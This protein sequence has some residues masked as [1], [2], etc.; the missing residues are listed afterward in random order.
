MSNIQQK[1]EEIKKGGA[2]KY[3]E[4]A[5]KNNKLF[6]RERIKL[7]LDPG[8]DFIE[9]GLFAN[10]EKEGLPADGVITVM[11]KISWP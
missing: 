7:L 6:A 2:E 10:C 3:H 5:R 9:D 1:I 4:Q 8:S 11:G